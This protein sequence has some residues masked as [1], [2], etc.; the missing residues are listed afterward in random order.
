MP[1]TTANP[2]FVHSTANGKA[3]AAVDSTNTYYR[4]FHQL[5]NWETI[6]NTWIDESGDRSKDTKFDINFQDLVDVTWKSFGHTE[7]DSAPPMKLNGEDMAAISQLRGH[8][9]FIGKPMAIDVERG[10]WDI[11]G[12]RYLE[13]LSETAPRVVTQ[14]FCK[15]TKFL[16]A[17]G[18]DIVLELPETIGTMSVG[19]VNLSGLRLPESRR[20]A[21]GRTITFT[22]G[23]RNYPWIVG[24]LAELV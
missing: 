12:L 22:T 24:V 14:P 3:K 7:L 20:S 23:Q 15:T 19:K 6:C 8:I 21:D 18:F 10:L 2:D 9:N 5:P 17:Q 16:M 1:C 4:P 11:K 13:P